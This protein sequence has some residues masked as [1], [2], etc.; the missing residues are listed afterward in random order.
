M[1]LALGMALKFYT[2]VAKGL[3]FKVRKFWRLIITFVEVAE[4][5]LVGGTFLPPPPF[6]PPNP[7][8]G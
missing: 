3:T 4:E 1:G 8:E 5:E 6:H 2:R 7:E